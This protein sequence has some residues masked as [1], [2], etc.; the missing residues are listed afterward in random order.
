M[1][2]AMV[3][4]W[5]EQTE[6]KS[7]LLMAAQMVDLM[8]AWKAQPM[9]GPMG[10]LSAGYSAYSR[11]DQKAGASADPTEH[12]SAPLMAAQMVD[13]MVGWKAQQMV[14][15]MALTSAVW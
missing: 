13:L 1:A 9:V 12:K 10:P 8:V 2:G 15:L 4:R 7:V 6:H 3:D 11:A 14:A 5:V